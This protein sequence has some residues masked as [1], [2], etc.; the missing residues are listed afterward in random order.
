[1]RQLEV[2]RN[3]ELAGILTEHDRGRYSFRYTDAW[4]ADAAKP[5]VS[6]TL[7]KTQQQYEAD[8]LF[9]IFFNILSE[10]VN[11]ALQ[12]RAFQIDE[13]DDFGLL[14]ATARIDTVGPITV[15]PIP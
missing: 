13:A 9:P 11:R 5:P 12:S 8:H 3:R 4:Y 14:S 15:K 1:M 10:G 7:P 6:L 2:Y